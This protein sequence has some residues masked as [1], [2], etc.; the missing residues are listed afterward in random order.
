MKTLIGLALALAASIILA[1]DDYI[2]K[3]TWYQTSS[4]DAAYTAVTGDGANN[5]YAASYTLTSGALADVY[6]RKVT[7]AGSTAWNTK[8]FSGLRPGVRPVKIVLDGSGNPY[9]LVKSVDEF[10]TPKTSYARVSASN[11]VVAWS[12]T[13][14]NRDPKG[15]A[16]IG[17]GSNGTIIKVVGQAWNPANTAQRNSFH[18]TKTEG[19]STSFT[20]NNVWD[21][22]SYDDIVA[23]NNG[24]FYVARTAANLRLEV[25]SGITQ[26]ASIQATLPGPYSGGKLAWNS[27][28]GGELGLV[29]RRS[30]AGGAVAYRMRAPVNNLSAFVETSGE[31]SDPPESVLFRADSGLQYFVRLI[32]GNV[33]AMYEYVSSTGIGQG[34]IQSGADVYPRGMVQDSKGAIHFATA[35]FDPFGTPS[36]LYLH[37]RTGFGSYSWKWSLEDAEP[38]AL[39]VCPNGTLYVAA[40]RLYF[41]NIPANAGALLRVVPKARCV[42]DSYDVPKDSTLTVPG[43]GVLTND[44]GYLGA[45][46]SWASPANGMLTPSSSGGFTYTPDAGYTGQ[47]IVTY[48]LT[49]EGFTSTAQIRIYVKPRLLEF[50]TPASIPGGE[51]ATGILKL[52]NPQVG[53]GV[54]VPLSDNSTAV[55]LP[56]SVYIGPGESQKVFA[57]TTVPVTSNRTATISGS[58]Y[59]DTKTATFSVLIAKPLSVGLSPNSLVGGQAF[60]GTVT[61]TGKAPAGGITVS[62]TDSGEYIVVPASVSILAGTKTATFSGTTTPRSVSLSRS[63]TATANGSSAVGSLTINPGGLYSLSATPSSVKGGFPSTGKVVTAGNTPTGG[64]TVALSAT[65]GNVSVPASVIVQQGTNQATFTITTTAVASTVNRTITAQWA[66]ITKTLTIVLTP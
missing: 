62:L 36:A 21:M 3:S 15:I 14:S 24:L 51:P 55:A 19:A 34:T 44:F 26:T 17:T 39:W 40:R 12:A 47:E 50:V 22:S 58:L 7:S 60:T 27:G 6:L 65:G 53:S 37:G 13:Y 2:L 32:Q 64:T 29:A 63:V 1:A 33:R 41:T 31:L 59:G 25:F 52:T 5:V 61:L 56:A 4:Y 30:P 42:L 38:H 18:F 16:V 10:G 11:G 57:I 43:P 49:K 45:S 23:G 48:S 54:N 28:N 66:T 35:L 9:L 8:V 46:L 20:N